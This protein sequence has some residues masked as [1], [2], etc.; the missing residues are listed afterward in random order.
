MDITLEMIT[1]GRA[2]AAKPGDRVVFTCGVRFGNGPHIEVGETGTVVEN[3]LC[4]NEEI[5]KIRLDDSDL[6]AQFK[7][8]KGCVSI[9]FNDKAFSPIAFIN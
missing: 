9:P 4:S 1:W 7:Q 2:I 3:K 5:L 8:S 6:A